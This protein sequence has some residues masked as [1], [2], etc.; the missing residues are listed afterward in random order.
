MKIII[1]LA[2]LAWALVALP[3]AVGAQ[4]AT[5]LANPAAK[6][7][8]AKG[9][10]S[11]IEKTPAGSEFGVCYFEDNRQCE[12]WALLRGECKAGGV[13]VTGYVTPASRYCAITGGGYEVESLS[14]LAHEQGTCMFTAG[15]SCDA[16]VY[17]NGSCT[18]TTPTP[19]PD[20]ATSV[21]PQNIQARLACAGGKRID[22]TFVNDPNGR[23]DLKLS[24]GRAV[25]LP[26]SASA[27]GARYASS[28]DAMVFWSI[29]STAFLQEG[30]TRTFDSCKASR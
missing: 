20:A 14:N 5:T 21:R 12:E 15:K 4:T 25:S 17:F 9:G 23:V 24:D 2:V 27:D 6:N 7:C 29:G 30:G 16:D 28:G 22:G 26:L 19:T 18:R 11:R 13:K 8:V 3:A 10:A 1:A